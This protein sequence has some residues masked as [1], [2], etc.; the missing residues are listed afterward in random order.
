MDWKYKHFNQ[1]AV[2]KAPPQSVLEAARAAVA[3]SLGESEITA[4]GF[5][6]RG[7]SGWNNVVATFHLT[8]TPQ[9]THAAVE[10]LAERLSIWGYLLF[11]IGGYYNSRIDK[12]FSGIARRLGDAQEQVLVSKTTSG[13]RVQRGC[14][15]GCLT[16]LILGTCLVIFA[17][18][19]DRAVFPQP[20]DS[21]VGPF[22]LLASLIGLAAGVAVLLY[23]I[24]PDAP[25][26]RFVR[27][28][29]PG[30]RD[31]EKRS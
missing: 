15:A 3:E 26:S 6:A 14:L 10:L 24:Y 17:I 2:F 7:Y 23:V 19:V 11:D 30:A 5:T 25:A 8:P 27:E 18:P 16:Y 31:R 22:S 20:A 12:W 29:L 13:V 1:Q 9:G 28:R 21:N 4:D